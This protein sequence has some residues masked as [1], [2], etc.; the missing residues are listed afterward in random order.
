MKRLFLAA[1]LLAALILSPS[2]AKADSDVFFIRIASAVTAAVVNST[3]A[4]VAHPL[5]YYA[6]QV[7][8][9]T[10]TATAWDVRLEGSLDGLNF[11]QIMGHQT[12]DGDGVM[13]VST[14]TIPFPVLYMRVRTNALTLGSSA[15]VINVTAIGSQ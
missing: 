9:S 15:S 12:S 6:L 7:K 3:Q 11:S 4:A 5:K 10:G 13:K 14:G 2:S 1:G 8:G